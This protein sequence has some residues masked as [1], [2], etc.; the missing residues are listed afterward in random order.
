LLS[1]HAKGDCHFP[2]GSFAKRESQIGG[3]ILQKCNQNACTLP[4]RE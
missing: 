4:A 2:F 1:F 3:C